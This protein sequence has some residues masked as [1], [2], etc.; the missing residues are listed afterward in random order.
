MVEFSDRDIVKGLK[1]GDMSSFQQL[2]DTK[3]SLFY[4]FIK[5]MIKNAWLAEDITQNIFMKVWIHRE[6]LNPNKS[7]HNYLYVLAKNEVRDHFKLKS[8]LNHQEIEDDD[9]SFVEDFEG[10]I[11]A[12]VMTKQVAAIVLQMPEQR[13]RIYLMSREEMMS[14][15]EIAEELNLS[16][17]TIERHIFL[18]LQD[19]RKSLPAFYLFLFAIFNS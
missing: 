14:N 3:Y 5:G 16:V 10:S 13:Q 9:K 12:E 15:N 6:K 2:F 7:L 19:I 17:R 8:N 1:K 18:A 4:A 11:D